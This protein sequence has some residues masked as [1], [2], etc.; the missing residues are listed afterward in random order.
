MANNYLDLVMT[1]CNVLPMTV[2]WM[3]EIPSCLYSNQ[4]LGSKR[5]L[6][7]RYLAGE[8]GILVKG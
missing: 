5:A 3:T 4:A 7:S 2:S 8:L 6:E 1:Y